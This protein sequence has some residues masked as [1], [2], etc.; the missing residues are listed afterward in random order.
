MCVESATQYRASTGG[1][2]ELTV[3]AV[4]K[5]RPLTG[6]KIPG[7]AKGGGGSR[8][9]VQVDASHVGRMGRVSRAVVREAVNVRGQRLHEKAQLAC[10]DEPE[11]DAANWMGWSM[12]QAS[13]V[14]GV[15][16]SAATSMVAWP[17][18]ALSSVVGKIVD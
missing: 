6:L 17:M 5:S 12:E 4:D 2:V 9:R 1:Q 18:R 10:L 14:A 11:E 8:K 13:I 16:S 3:F 15:S 7:G